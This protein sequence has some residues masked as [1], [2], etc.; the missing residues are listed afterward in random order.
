MSDYYQLLGV[1]RKATDKEIK[2]A[3]HRRLRKIHPD[4]AGPGHEEEVK[5]VNK[6][7]EVLSDPEKRQMYDLGGED[8]LSGRGPAAGAGDFG[9]FAS[10]F[11]SMF[12]GAFGGGGPRSRQSPGSDRVLPVELDLADVAFGTTLKQD[13]EVYVLCEQCQLHRPGYL[14]GDLHPVPRQRKRAAHRTLPIWRN[15]HLP[16]LP[17]L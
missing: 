17:T 4:Y 3:Y 8:A 11:S 9:A 16:A 5:Q 14:A 12:G 15:A 10:A 1:D 6:A 2:R 7:Y 13:I